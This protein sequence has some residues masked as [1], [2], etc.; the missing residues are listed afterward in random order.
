[1]L[2]RFLASQNCS[3]KWRFFENIR[4]KILSIVIVTQERQFLTRNR[5][6]LRILRKN[7]LKRVAVALLKNPK[8]EQKNLSTQRQGKITYLCSRNP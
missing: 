2:K 8:N 4:V 7:S 1:M 3:T 5:V 6:F